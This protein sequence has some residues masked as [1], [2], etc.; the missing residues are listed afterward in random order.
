[1]NDSI[2][3]ND[4]VLDN[5]FHTKHVLFALMDNKFNFIRVNKAYAEADNKNPSFYLR[6]NHFK[7]Y[8]NEENET[9]FKKVVQTG[10]SHTVNEKSFEYKY[11]P[12]RGTSYWEWTL[13]PIKNSNQN[14]TMVLLELVNITEKV[15]IKNN[16]IKSFKNYKE[17]SE[18]RNS[19][20]IL[21]ICS[22]CKKIKEKGEI[23]EP[24]DNYLLKRIKIKFSHG[25]C[26]NC[27]E[28]V[29]KEI[30]EYDIFKR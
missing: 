13:H 26:P 27:A 25:Y 8:P 21:T 18:D 28:H 11:N 4:I 14:V 3:K 16:L 20:E 2:I 15:N 12:E 22:Y 7:L 17:S 5:F 29:M 10:I 24:I 23:W 19:N 30:E 1:M 6:K 9:I